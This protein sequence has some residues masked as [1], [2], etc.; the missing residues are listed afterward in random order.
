M[1]KCSKGLQGSWLIGEGWREELKAFR[2]FL[3]SQIGCTSSS[4]RSALKEDLVSGRM[5]FGV[6]NGE[7]GWV[8]HLVPFEGSWCTSELWNIPHQGFW[9]W[10]CSFGLNDLILKLNICLILE[11]RARGEDRE[12]GYRTTCDTYQLIKIS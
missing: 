7:E 3:C 12:F 5:H 11:Y 9:V 1:L 4:R 10:S 6:R 2:V 8:V